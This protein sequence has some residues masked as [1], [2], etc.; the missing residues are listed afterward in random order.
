M[1]KLELDLQI[2]YKKLFYADMEI[3][4]QPQTVSFLS[5]GSYDIYSLVTH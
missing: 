1:F 3:K 2:S 4:I 5:L